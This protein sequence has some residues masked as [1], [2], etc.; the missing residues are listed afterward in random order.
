MTSI[1]SVDDPVLKEPDLDT[2]LDEAVAKR[3]TLDTATPDPAVED[4][5]LS[6]PTVTLMGGLPEFEPMDPSGPVGQLPNTAPVEEEQA[7]VD[8]T[9]SSPQETGNGGSVP[10]E[11]PKGPSST[12]QTIAAW[13][14]VAVAAVILAQ[15]FGV[16]DL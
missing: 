13:G 5:P 14:G 9:S 7:P 10:G 11:T 4:E 3:S 12:L 8:V 16:I 1:V 2:S 6:D 15:T